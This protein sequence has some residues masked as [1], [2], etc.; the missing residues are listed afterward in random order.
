MSDTSWLTVTRGDAPLLVSI[1]HTGTELLDLEPRLVSPWLA[2]K[3]GDWW[4][5]KLYDFATE[6]GA[7]VVR[8]TISRTIIDV[9]RD[10][11]GASLYPGQATTG[12]C[13]TTTFD[14]EPIYR[15]G[16]APDATEIAA[17][18]AAYFDPYDRALHDEVARLRVGHRDVVLYDCHSIRSAIPRLFE[19]ELPVFNLGTNSGASADRA[20]VECCVDILRD[21]GQSFVV[22]GRFKGG[23][24]TRSFGEPVRG[25]HALQMEI[26]CRGYMREPIGPVTSAD[27]PTPYDPA[28]PAR[29]RDTLRTLLQAALAWARRPHS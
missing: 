5:E 21:S 24:I 15:E 7:T 17:R 28:Y 23:W 12:L 13:P 9:N 19:G 1:P 8:T 3:D 14:G 27:W 20:L 10:P 22:D 4:I 11:S 16:Q 25:V 2:R 6:L 29:T 18:R 26:A